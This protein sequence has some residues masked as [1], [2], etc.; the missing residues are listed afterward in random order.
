MDLPLEFRAPE[1]LRTQLSHFSDLGPMVATILTRYPNARAVRANSAYSVYFHGE[2]FNLGL[3]I[4]SG[5]TNILGI[6]KTDRQGHLLPKARTFFNS[7]EVIESNSA[8]GFDL[9]EKRTP[10]FTCFVC[11]RTGGMPLAVG[12][13]KP[14]LPEPLE[15]T[16]KTINSWVAETA[17]AEY[18]SMD[19]ADFGPTF[20]PVN[21]IA[22]PM[23][24]CALVPLVAE[25]RKPSPRLGSK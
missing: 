25:S 12:T 8:S 22:E 16:L 2:N 4:Q 15:L 14:I 17:D 7:Y 18:D 10:P 19:V 20:G 11:H 23:S 1:F 3:E 13:L 24:S 6:Q 5:R 9:R 21:P